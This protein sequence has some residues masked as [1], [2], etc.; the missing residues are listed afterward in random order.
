MVP[1][2]GDHIVGLGLRIIS[3]AVVLLRRLDPHVADEAAEIH[4]ALPGEVDR[5]LRSIA[6][7]R[8]AAAAR[9]ASHQ[10]SVRA[11]RDAA[12]PEDASSAI[13]VAVVGVSA[14]QPGLY[15]A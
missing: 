10:H 15:R 13:A 9:H 6:I 12:D 4:S 5:G 11:G 7:A 3:V 1:V 2:L 8:I 14:V